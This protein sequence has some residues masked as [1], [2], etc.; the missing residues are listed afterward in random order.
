MP[1]VNGLIKKM[2]SNDLNKFSLLLQENYYRQNL[3]RKEE[4]LFEQRDGD[5]LV[6]HTSNFILVKVLTPK[7]YTKLIKPVL[8]KK[9]DDGMVLGELLED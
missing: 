9:Y 6:G 5:Y 7:D 1:Q 4:V 2:R 8:L 3:G